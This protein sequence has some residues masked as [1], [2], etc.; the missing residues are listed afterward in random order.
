MPDGI[1]RR[2]ISERGFGFIQLTEGEQLFFHS[3]QLQGITL[4]AL[5]EGQQVKFEI[6]Q[7]R[8]GPIAI[9]IRPYTDG[10]KKGLESDL[11][12]SGFFSW[13]KDNIRAQR[14]AFRSRDRK[15]SGW[16]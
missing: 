12:D 2:L 7:G 11:S 14:R 4:Q 8:K 13:G 16:K 3:N 1:I 10:S 15:V 5:K 9:K 6:S